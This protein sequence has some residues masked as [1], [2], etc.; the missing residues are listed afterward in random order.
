[1]WPEACQHAYQES[2]IKAAGC[3]V[4][5]V[6]RFTLEVCDD[7]RSVL[8]SPALH[9]RHVRG[10]VHGFYLGC[11]GRPALQSPHLR[12]SAC[13][14]CSESEPNCPPSL[15]MAVVPSC[16]AGYRCLDTLCQ[17]D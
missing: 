12:A 13:L 3:H 5:G 6:V 8:G 15:L 7:A 9:D 1:M 2:V 17:A 11:A 4:G 14:C 10:R 16:T